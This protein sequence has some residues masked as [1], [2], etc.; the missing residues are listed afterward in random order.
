MENNRDNVSY[1]LQQYCGTCASYNIYCIY[2]YSP[3][4]TIKYNI[5]LTSVI[6]KE[7]IFKYYYYYY[8]RSLKQSYVAGKK[9]QKTEMQEHQL[10]GRGIP[11]TRCVS[12][13][14]YLAHENSKGETRGRS[15]HKNNN[16]I[17][18]NMKK[19]TWALWGKKVPNK[20]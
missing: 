5:F 4:T 18:R 13:S 9:L 6:L 11:C 10:K 7:N 20:A 19:G 14:R 1:L 15:R 12:H 2:I 17:V 3:W 8:I 16:N